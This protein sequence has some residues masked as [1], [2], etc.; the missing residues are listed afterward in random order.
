MLN[1]AFSNSQNLASEPALHFS[2]RLEITCTVFTDGNGKGVY[3]P[4]LVTIPNWD[5]AGTWGYNAG[6]TLEVKYENFQYSL[7][8]PQFD[9]KYEGTGC[10]AGSIMTF[11]EVADLYGFFPGTHAV[12]DN[13]YLDGSEVT[14]DATKVLDAND[15]SKYRL[16]LWNC[17]GVTKNA[18]CAFGT[19][20]GDVIKELGFSTSMEVKF[21]FHK[22]FAVPQW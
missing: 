11:I 10:A 14:F 5:G 20:D 12:L 8:A 4:N 15:S 7:V 1:S 2:N 3:T 17:Y 19:P 13:L 9:I 21:T 22:L 6:G 18:G 16:E